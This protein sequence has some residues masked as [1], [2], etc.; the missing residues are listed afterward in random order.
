MYMYMDVYM[1]NYVNLMLS[2]I[3]GLEVYMYVNGGNQK[4]YI[5]NT[6]LELVATTGD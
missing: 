1:Y 6:I 4:I 5:S 2:A 3:V